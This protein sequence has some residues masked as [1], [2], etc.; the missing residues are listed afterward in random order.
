MTTCPVRSTMPE[1]ATQS[2]ATNGAVESFAGARRRSISRTSRKVAAAAQAAPSA[3][4]NWPANGPPPVTGRSA[5][6][7]AG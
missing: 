2:P 5:A 7:A 4:T 6:T 1:A 3:L